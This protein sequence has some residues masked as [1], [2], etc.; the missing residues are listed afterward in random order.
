M[1]ALIKYLDGK[2]TYLLGA[3]GALVN[4]L[5]YT[6]HL[7]QDTAFMLLNTMGFGAILTTRTA[8]SKTK[9]Q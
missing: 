2:K 3:M 9:R 7:D 1:G 6:G 4:F 5:M 8:I